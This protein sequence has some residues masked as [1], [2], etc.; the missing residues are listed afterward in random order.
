MSLSYRHLRLADVSVRAI[1]VH[2]LLAHLV[3]LVLL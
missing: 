2:Q 1:A 3:Q